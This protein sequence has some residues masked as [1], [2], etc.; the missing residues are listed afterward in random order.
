MRFQHGQERPPARR[1][2]ADAD[3]PS[4]RGTRFVR[5]N[6]RMSRRCLISASGWAQLIWMTVRTRLSRWIYGALAAVGTVA[7]A[8][9]AI[10]VFSVAATRL[11]VALL[12]FT[13]AA[14]VIG[15]LGL[16]V[17]YR[18]Y[19]LEVGKVPKPD[20][21][22]LDDGKTTKRWEVQIELLAVD[23]SEVAAAV[24]RETRAMEASI[25]KVEEPRANR[26]SNSIIDFDVAGHIND[27]AM[28]KYR[29]EV[30]DYLKTYEMCLRAKRVFDA[31][32]ARSRDVTFAF[33]NDRA[34]VPA[35]G[36]RVII[37]V[38]DE[39]R[40]LERS[41]FPENPVMPRRP[42]PPRS[43]SLLGDIAGLGRGFDTS[44][45]LSSMRPLPV[46]PGRPG[47]V[48]WPTIRSGTSTEIAFKVEEILH[49]IGDDSHE[50]PVV[51]AFPRAGTWTIRYEMHARNLP[52]P[53]RGELTIT[54]TV[55]APSV[56]AKDA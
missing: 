14:A 15:Y 9:Y 28:K 48:S 16:I 33:T 3:W 41:Q 38:P 37:H 44:S 22:I 42:K 43:H 50:H 55:K 13:T 25:A 18:L 29:T 34:G 23:E 39:V 30:S 53:K 49:N 2:V 4:L 1:I 52:S 19:R 8:L 20:L 12:V 36:V 26:P 45:L 35:E 32:S 40:V 24:S 11:E 46:I 51:L 31:L 10:S 6:A 54:T 7:A 47:N 56:A 21:A 17:S 5:S 27:D